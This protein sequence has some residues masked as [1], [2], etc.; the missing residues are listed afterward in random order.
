MSDSIYA[1]DTAAADLFAAGDGNLFQRVMQLRAAAQQVGGAPDPQETADPGLSSNEEPMS[2]FTTVRPNLVQ[3]IRAFRVQDLA[4]E[5]SRLGQH[6]LYAYC[7][8]AQSK[9]EVMETI[10]TSFLFPKHFGKNYD[11]LYDCLTDLV[12]KAGAQPGFVIVLEGL[13]I[14]Q[15]FDKEGRE[16]LLDVFREAAEFWAERKVAFRVFY[17]FA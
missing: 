1:H 6:F 16:T 5:A 14:A 9:Q 3:S 2:L 17:S 7:G 13:P 11:A 10:A 8:A 4:D 15:K 12:A